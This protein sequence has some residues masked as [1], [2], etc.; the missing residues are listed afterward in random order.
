MARLVTEEM[1]REGQLKERNGVRD[2]RYFYRLVE[3]RQKLLPLL[4]RQY[5]RAILTLQRGETGA[6]L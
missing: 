6:E 5:W 1:N 3:V 4:P 2:N